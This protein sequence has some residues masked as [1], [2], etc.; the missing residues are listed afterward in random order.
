MKHHSLKCIATIVLTL[1]LTGCFSAARMAAHQSGVT[2]SQIRR[3][4]DRDCFLALGPEVVGRTELA[5]GGYS[6]T[7]RAKREKGS[8]LRSFLQGVLTVG[9]LGIWN[10]VGVPMEGMIS[11]NEYIVFRVTYDSQGGMKKAEIQ[12]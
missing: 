9:T 4:T 7:Y 5:D 2:P 8:T 3:C 12:G 11:S 1:S 6:E 10:V